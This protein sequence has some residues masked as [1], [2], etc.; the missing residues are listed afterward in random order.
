MLSE[1]E[2]GREESRTAQQLYRLPSHPE[3]FAQSASSAERRRSVSSER[4]RSCASRQLQPLWILLCFQPRLP[5][6]FS[7]V[8][9]EIQLHAGQERSFTAVQRECLQAC[10]CFLPHMH[11]LA[12]VCFSL[13]VCVRA[14]GEE[15]TN[16]WGCVSLRNIIRD[17]KQSFCPTLRV[18]VDFVNYG[19]KS[20]ADII[21]GREQHSIR[22][23]RPL[24]HPVGQM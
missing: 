19:T 13:C 18:F 3:L 16:A 7:R 15:V 1:Q 24:S 21:P 12:C 14:A 5:L 17:V 8:G 22:T 9:D 6:R 11:F 4:S 23:R 10:L 20:P 2:V